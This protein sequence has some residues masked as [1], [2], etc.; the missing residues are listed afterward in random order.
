MEGLLNNVK[1]SLITGHMNNSTGS[2]DTTGVSYVDMAGYDGVLLIGIP[3]EAIATAVMGIYPYTGATV[4]TLATGST[5]IYAGTTSATT[6]MEEMVFALDLVKPKTRYVSA[7]WDKNT[8]ASG[9]A[10][11]AIQYNGTEKPVSQSTEL[12]GCFDAQTFA[13]AT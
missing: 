5:A 6:A 9:G 13:G 2:T 12:Y 4:A 11:L 3:T 10:I 8:A 1:V 7:R